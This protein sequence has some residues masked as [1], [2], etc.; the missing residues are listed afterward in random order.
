MMKEI[1][2]NQQEKISAIALGCMRISGMN[3]QELSSHVHA[4]LDLGITFFDHADIYGKGESEV[5]FG[6]LLALE[7]DLRKRIFLQDKCGICPGYY[8]SSREHILESVENSLKKLQ[9]EYL[10]A[11]LIHR[12]DVLA[13]PDEIAEAFACLKKEGK[14]RY[15]GVSNHTPDQMEVLQQAVGDRLMFNQMQLSLVHTP[16]IDQGIQTNTCFAGAIDKDGGVLD[17]MKRTHR[18]LQVWS[19]FQHGFIEGPFIDNPDFPEV[20]QALQQM[21]EKYDT[22]K[23]TIATAWLLRLPLSLQ[24]ITGTTSAKRLREIASACEIRLAAKDWYALYCAAGNQ[25]P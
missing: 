4:A 8:D 17:Y 25:L 2:L 12:P 5:R 20:N 18:I 14:V 22:S 15:F 24:V 21:A 10:D 1:Q 11:L 19:P 16:M 13:D 6:E 23:T 7:P 9:T 3:V